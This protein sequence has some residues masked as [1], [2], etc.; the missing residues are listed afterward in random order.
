MQVVQRE[1]V[2]AILLYLAGTVDGLTSLGN[3][4]LMHTTAKACMGVCSGG[5]LCIDKGGGASP[6]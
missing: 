2:P 1:P 5:S 3:S 6:I 4:S